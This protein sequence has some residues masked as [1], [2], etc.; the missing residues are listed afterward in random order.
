MNLRRIPFSKTVNFRD[1]GGYATPDGMTKFNVFFRSACPVDFDEKDKEKFAALN[2]GT[3][4]DLRGMTNFDFE[5]APPVIDGVQTLNFPL[6]GGSA[7]KRDR[8][9]APS[10][11]GMLKC[12][13]SMRGIFE[14][15]ADAEKGVMFHCFAGKDR[16]GVV[17][18]LLLSLVGVSRE[19]IVA[20][21]C[22]SYAYYIEKLRNFYG[23][24][25]VRK[26]SL[27][28]PEHMEVFLQ[29]FYDKYGSVEEYLCGIGVDNARQQKIKDKFVVKN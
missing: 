4:V 25:H 15:F 9:V 11:L 3:V 17:A 20:D 28:L 7:P 16:T 18:A 8:D 21:Y 10:Y 14:T 12:T 26:V 13:E 5:I 1:L 24:G 23:K 6:S 19:D 22:L 29:R 27:S 2:I